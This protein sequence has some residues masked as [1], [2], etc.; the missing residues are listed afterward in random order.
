MVIEA[1]SAKCL[2]E[3]K[4]RQTMG[5]RNGQ[6]S[7][8]VCAN[9]LQWKE[10]KGGQM[11]GVNEQESGATLNRKSGLN[12]GYSALWTII[13]ISDAILFSKRII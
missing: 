13:K 7:E 4:G 6:M 1:I 9:V 8:T 5:E 3:E 2:D 12:P 10:V 11:R